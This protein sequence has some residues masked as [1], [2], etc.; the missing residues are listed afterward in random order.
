ML[1]VGLRASSLLQSLHSLALLCILQFRFHVRGAKRGAGLTRT[2]LPT[3]LPRRW[4]GRQARRKANRRQPPRVS[5]PKTTLALQSSA[6]SPRPAWLERQESFT[7]GTTSGQWPLQAGREGAGLPRHHTPVMSSLPA[8]R[9]AEAVAPYHG[10][11]AST[12]VTAAAV[13]GLCGQ[14]PHGCLKA[15]KAPVNRVP[16][17]DRRFPQF[18][19]NR[20][21]NALL[22]AFEHLH[23]FR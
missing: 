23:I 22:T 19:H 20:K 6:L 21:H 17:W 16:S 12:A 13:E 4:R 2:I 9:H 3:R 5:V 18:P 7:S 14:Q 8:P 1:K 15:P 10:T 11:Q